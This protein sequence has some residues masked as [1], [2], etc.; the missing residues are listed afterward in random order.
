MGKMKHSHEIFFEAFG[1]WWTGSP[2]LLNAY[3]WVYHPESRWH[4]SHELVYHAPLYYG[5]CAI[6]FHHSVVIPWSSSPFGSSKLISSRLFLTNPEQCQNSF[7]HLPYTL[8]TFLVCGFSFENMLVKLGIF[9]PNFRGEKLKQTYLKPAPSS[10]NAC[11]K[12]SPW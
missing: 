2:S 4:N 1:G 8:E 10:C 12:R 11:S 6:Y 7:K 9:S 3:D 5:S